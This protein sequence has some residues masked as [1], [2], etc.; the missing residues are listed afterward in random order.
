MEEVNLIKK[1][2]SL[3]YEAVK[4]YIKNFCKMLL[5]L[6]VIDMWILMVIN[7]WILLSLVLIKFIPCK[8]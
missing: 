1:Q 6:V 8:M 7:I 2:L 4:T 5:L 3:V